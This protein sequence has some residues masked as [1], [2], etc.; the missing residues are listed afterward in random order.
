MMNMFL[1][2][3]VFQK[4]VTN[5]LQKHKYGNAAQDDLWA[6][7][8]ETAHAQGVLQSN[9]T[10]KMIMDTWTV[11]TGFPVVTVTRDYEKSTVTVTQVRVTSSGAS[12]RAPTTMRHLR[13]RI[14]RA[15]LIR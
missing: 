10:V 7:L 9:V 8:T 1:G 12:A 14:L 15:S 11:Q 4:S 5:Y 6:A 3:D 2:E 13:P